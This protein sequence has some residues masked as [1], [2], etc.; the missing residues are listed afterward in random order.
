VTYE[1]GFAD[2]WTASVD[3]PQPLEGTAAGLDADDSWIATGEL[4]LPSERRVSIAS[5]LMVEWIPDGELAQ[6]RDATLQFVVRDESGNVIAP[7]PYMG[8]AAHLILRRDDGSVFTHLHPSGS[9]SMAAQQ[10]FELRAE[11]K[12]PLDVA[13]S[14]KDP[15]CKLPPLDASWARTHASHVISFPYAF[16]KAGRYRLWLQTKVRGEVR[17]AVFD[18]EVAAAV[19]AKNAFAWR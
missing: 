10:L 4:R 14:K 8:M 2:T 13:S 19:P 18:T 1:S 16:P 7:E 6:E 17:T 3:L 5:G 15:I 11:G 12:A 9:F